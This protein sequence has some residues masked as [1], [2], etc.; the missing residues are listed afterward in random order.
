MRIGHY[1]AMRGLLSLSND[2]IQ[3][4]DRMAYHILST[5]D[6]YDKDEEF[7]DNESVASYN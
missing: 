2:A 7:S 4:R 5:E 1:H 6:F 3:D